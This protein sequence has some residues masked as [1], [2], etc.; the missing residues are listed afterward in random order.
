VVIAASTL[1]MSHKWA[2]THRR[3][4]MHTQRPCWPDTSQSPCIN[5]TVDFY[6]L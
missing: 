4:E 1:I 6:Y 5:R 3:F 2:D